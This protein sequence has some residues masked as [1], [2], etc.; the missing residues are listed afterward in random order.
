M[1]GEEFKRFSDSYKDEMLQWLQSDHWQKWY[2][3][4]S[5]VEQTA[6][7]TYQGGD[8]YKINRFLRKR[9]PLSRD[10]QKAIQNL[11]NAIKKGSIPENIVAC[12][13]FTNPVLSD[14][15]K[16]E[17]KENIR[18]IVNVDDGFLSTSLSYEYCYSKKSTGQKIIM[19]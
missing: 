9:E 14:I 12:R 5:A 1:R 16:A 8:S 2:N 17:G 15:I 10:S 13:G 7:G 11:D 3:G 19:E 18:G 4:L 6:L